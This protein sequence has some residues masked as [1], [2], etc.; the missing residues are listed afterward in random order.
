VCQRPRAL[1]ARV[2]RARPHPLLEPA[3]VPR[4]SGNE[5]S[6]RKHVNCAHRWV[7]AEGHERQCNYNVFGNDPEE[8]YNNLLESRKSFLS[9]GVQGLNCKGRRQTHCPLRSRRAIIA[10]LHNRGL[11]SGGEQES[12]QGDLQLGIPSQRKYSKSFD[13]NAAMRDWSQ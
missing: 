6:G 4:I 8:A 10:R 13:R 5:L 2:Q 12:L 7:D 9:F 1:V 11:V 3:A